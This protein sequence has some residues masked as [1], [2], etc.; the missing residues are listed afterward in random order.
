MKGIKMHTPRG[1]ER[2][3]SHQE[4]VSGVSEQVLECLVKNSTLRWSKSHASFCTKNS[5][6]LETYKNESIM[7]PRFGSF[8]Y[9][10]D[11][12]MNAILTLNLTD[13]K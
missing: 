13:K 1:N 2:S 11:M 10:N 8:R 7:V 6:F 5:Y 9:L 4:G 3:A 12:Q